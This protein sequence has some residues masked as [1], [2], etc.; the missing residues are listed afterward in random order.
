M[1]NIEKHEDIKKRERR[2]KT[3]LALL[4]VF[5]LVVSTIGFAFQGFSDDSN[6]ENSVTSHGV[7]FVQYQGFWK[8]NI[9]DVPLFFS[10]LP[11]EVSEM[12]TSFEGSVRNLFELKEG[13]AYI[14]SDNQPA[15]DELYRNLFYIANNVQ[16]A[17][18][19]G[20]ECDNE[21]LPIKTCSDNIFVIK[22]SEKNEIKTENNCV[23]IYG[24]YSDLQ[25]IV[26]EYLYKSIGILK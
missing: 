25:K 16:Q 15:E 10:Y 5:L 23:F 1:K 19:E 12:N 11:E 13:K 2:S 24:K 18:L 3:I 22:E 17:C 8:T 4:F 21:E 14:D 26:D 9:Q 6:N 7:D 20:E